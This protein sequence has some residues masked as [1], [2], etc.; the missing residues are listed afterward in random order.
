MAELVGVVAS[1]VTF[2]TVV[3]QLA[4]TITTLKAFWDQV[5][6]AP[7]DLKWYIR[8]IEIFSFVLADIKADIAQ[9]STASSLLS[10]KSVVKTCQLFS[11]ATK[12]LD[13]L[14][15]DFE[16][17]INSSSRLLRSYAAVKIMMKKNKVEKYRSR[18][19]TVTQLLSLSQQCY[20][21]LV[22]PLALN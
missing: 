18:L 3:G 13:T 5:N 12:E 10:N 11:E 17:D 21:R 1:A 9:D 22:K 14:L 6:D 20:T 4:T 16:R 7:D 2:A 8:E 19:K 15:K